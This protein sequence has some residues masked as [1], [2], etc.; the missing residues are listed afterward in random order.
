MITAELLVS[1]IMAVILQAAPLA[2]LEARL[3]PRQLTEAATE[4]QQ[5]YLMPSSCCIRAMHGTRRPELFLA[6]TV[7]S[8]ST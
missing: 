2:E 8:P 4:H 6:L 3:G 5:R 7:L 1:A